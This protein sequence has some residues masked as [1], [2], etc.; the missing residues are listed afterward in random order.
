MQLVTGHGRVVDLGLALAK[1]GEGAVYEISGAQSLVAKIYHHPTDTQKQRKLAFMCGASTK[2]LKQLTAWP[3]HTLHRH[4]G[5]PMVGFV[6]PRLSSCDPVHSIYSPAE[7]KQ[8]FPRRGWDFLLYVARNTAAA[9]DAVHQAGHVIGDV[10]QNNVMVMGDSRVVLIDT[11]SFQVTSPQEVH[12]CGV[13]VPHFTPPELQGA[14]DFKSIHRTAQH[15][16]FGLALLIFHLLCGGRHPFSGKPCVAGA[17]NSLEEDIRH[18]RYAY[19]GEGAVRGMLP[20][21]LSIPI[22]TLP[23]QIQGMFRYAFTEPG[24]KG[25]RPSAS[26]WVTALD[27]LRGSLRRCTQSGVHIHSGHLE[28]CPWCELEENG[29]VL[30]LPDYTVAQAPGTVFNIAKVWA[31]IEAVRFPAGPSATTALNHTCVPRP[32]P[33]AAKVDRRKQYRIAVWAGAVV[34][35]FLFP[36]YWFLV[37]VALGVGLMV[38]HSAVN[39]EMTKE[40]EQ[41]QATLKLCQKSLDN[42]MQQGG[43]IVSVGNIKMKKRDLE[44]ARDNWIAMQAEEKSQLE[45]LVRNVEQRQ[46]RLFLERFLIEKAPIQGVGN[47][48][49]ATLRSFGIE[50][51]ADVDLQSVMAVSGFGPVLTQATLDWRDRCEKLFTFDPSQTVTQADRQAV[52]NRFAGRRSFIESVLLKGASELRAI[53]GKAVADVQD[54]E[55]QLRTAALALAQAKADMSV[56]S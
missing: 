11:D 27:S 54:Y 44:K 15:D 51:A 22:K 53:E 55:R 6:M 20:P 5:G 41:R 18:L 34:G 32:L 8:K 4:A 36:S 17:G 48:K 14:G 47:A 40:R 30:F 46:R 31:A 26:Q 19:S 50:T 25:Q 49:K 3:Q 2:Q 56:C 42:L 28:L 16:L 23:L 9:F 29:L 21:P 1:G 52:L 13:G 10:N 12:I 37:C 33:V 7:R 38:A 43:M 45:G 35:L 24:T 39:E